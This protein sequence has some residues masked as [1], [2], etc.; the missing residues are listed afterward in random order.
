[1]TA[2][3]HASVLDQLRGAGLLVD[4]LETGRLVRCKVEGDRERRGWYSLHEVVTSRGDTLIFGSFGVW[5]G[6]DNGAQKIELKKFDLTQEQRAAIKA[7]TREDREAAERVRAGEAKRAAERARAAW[8]KCSESGD[9]EY[10]ARKGIGA[11]GVRFSPSGALVVP[12]LDVHGKIW[13]LQVIRSRK[14]AKADHRPEKEFW[15]RGLVKK[16]RFHL[17]GMPAPGGLV[18]IAEGYATAAS[19]YEATQ[20][21]TAVAFDAGNLAPVTAALRKRY[22]NVRLLICADDDAFTEGNPGVTAASTAAAESGGAWIKPIFADEAARRE[23]FDKRKVKLTDFNDLHLAEGLQAVRVQIYAKLAALKWSQTLMVKAKAGADDAM[24]P[25]QTVDELLPRFSLV[26]GGQGIAF[27]HAQ[28]RRLALSDLRDACA[29]R[30]LFRSWMES[31]E[32]KM[33]RPEEVGFDPTGHDAAITCNLWAGWPTSPHA[34][35]CEKLLDVLRHMTSGDL[36]PNDLFAW[37]LRWLAFPIQHPGA[38]MKTALVV[39]GPQGTGKNLFFE[40][41]LSI[42]G[43]YG[44]VLDQLAIEDKF[45][46]WASRMLFLIADE[47]IART[48]VFHVKNRLKAFITGS[49]IRINP[50][51]MPAYVERNHVNMV[52][53]SNEGTPVAIDEDDRRHC[54]IFTPEKREPQFYREVAAEIQAGGVEALHDYLLTL[55]LGDF[56]EAT[57][58]PYTN[59]KADLVDDSLDTVSR[60]YYALQAQELGALKLVPAPME[61]VYKVYKAFCA[62]NGLRSTTLPKTR[63]VLRRRHRIEV[64]RKRY[65][66]RAAHTM[67]S[68]VLFDAHRM[69]PGAQETIWLGE[70]VEAWQT[71]SEQ[72][73]AEA[74]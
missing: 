72:Y 19:L 38:K 39:H 73:L 30:E 55:D 12:M 44:R 4:T 51:G 24:R 6:A 22:R 45:N 13:G 2:A 62:Q 32:R 1:M 48:E 67:R 23:A 52:F 16:E 54:V 60:F 63:A 37:V 34:G 27:D 53:L 46:D 7:R 47:V 3:N 65:V 68:I 56:N 57:P 58:P 59:A 40:A 61:E 74:A 50:K 69:P 8:T 35:A 26:Y 11:H 29:H 31:P 70:C 17:L 9:S 33:V 5:H 42:Y 21:P 18:L 25:F 41:V 49:T 71:A 10:L 14:R 15:P 36:R 64:Q 43:P 66:A 28:R 20:I